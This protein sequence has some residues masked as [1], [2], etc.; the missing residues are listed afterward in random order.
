MQAHSYLQEMSD[1]VSAP[2]VL[3]ERVNNHLIHAWALFQGFTPLPSIRNHCANP[4]GCPAAER[5]AHF[6]TLLAQCCHHVCELL[7]LL[8]ASHWAHLRDIFLCVLWAQNQKGICPVGLLKWQVLMLWGSCR[9]WQ[10]L[11]KF[12][13]AAKDRY[14][15]FRN[16]GQCSGVSQGQRINKNCNYSLKTLE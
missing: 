16:C 7:A 6:Q 4:P 13:K 10:I 1:A 8:W 15:I 14:I 9:D 5:R 11:V 3:G 2:S 12:K